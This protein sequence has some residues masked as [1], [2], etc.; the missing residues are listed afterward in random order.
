[1]TH[2]SHT[3]LLFTIFIIMVGTPNL[4]TVTARTTSYSRDQVSC[5]MCDECENPCQPPPSPPPPSP[6]PPADTNCPP[7]P[8]PPSPTSNP[9]PATPSVP[10]FPYYSPPPPPPGGG[11]YGYPTPPPPNP[12]LPY[13]PFYYYNP[14][15]PG[16]IS[17]S[18]PGRININ[19]VQNQIILPV[20]FIIIFFFV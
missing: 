20:F 12:I 13:F 14:P 8:S 16:Q 6:P 1:M 11:G 19:R 17:G 18:G 2:F 3:S 10:N 7:P 4:R 15:P 9:P 5:T